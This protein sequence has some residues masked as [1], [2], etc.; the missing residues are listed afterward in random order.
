MKTMGKQRRFQSPERR[1][2]GRTPFTGR[3]RKKR[4]GVPS[5]L[6]AS[7][8]HALSHVS[9]PLPHNTLRARIWHHQSRSKGRLSEFQATATPAGLI[10][11]SGSHLA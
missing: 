4:G 11:Y 10:G 2:K 5:K 7:P 1:G 8:H 3:K 6:P 9:K